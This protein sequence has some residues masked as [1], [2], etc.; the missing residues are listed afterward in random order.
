MAAV[1]VTAWIPEEHSGRVITRV[2]R[3]SAAEQFF[4][5]EPMGSSSKSVP[6][7]A[8]I[9]SEVVAKSGTYAE[10]DSTNDDVTLTARKFGKAVRIAEEDQ[11]DALPDVLA[12]K[13]EGWA[14][15]Y[16]RHLDNACLAVTA[17]SNGGTI[18]FTSLYRALAQENGNGGYGS[19]DNITQTGTGGTT[20]DTL[21]TAFGLYEEGDFFEEGD[22]VVIA[23]PAYKRKLRGLK[24]DQGMPI[25]VRGQG[26]DAGTPDSIFGYRVAWSQGAKTS[27]TAVHNP[28]GNPLLIVGNRNYAILGIRSGP[29]SM[30]AGPEAAFLTD[31]ALL[32]MRARRAY[33]TGEHGAWSIHEDN[34]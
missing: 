25:L 4:R 33:A 31:E 15:A 8:G 22:T 9:D 29:E 26:G 2:R 5:R 21:N 23:S 34:S 11:G 28:A 6:R 10:D 16:A 27:A 13:R 30:V 32:K 24:D 3:S 18:P 14:G 1:T 7:D 17:A 19:G 12:S 20:Y